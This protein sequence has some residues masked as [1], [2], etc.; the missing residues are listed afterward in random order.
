MQ[1]NSSSLSSN[2]VLDLYI[3]YELNN[4]PHNLSSDFTI[5]NCS[6]GTVKLT[7][8]TIK[9]KFIYNGPEITF[10]GAGSWRYGNDFAENVIVFS[11]NNSSSIHTDNRKNSFL[12]IGE[13]LT[14]L[15]IVFV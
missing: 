10:D 9:S 14:D 6:V 7:G 12:V 8:N 13:G 15:M 5:R 1:Q 2:F 11:L 4:W 3:V